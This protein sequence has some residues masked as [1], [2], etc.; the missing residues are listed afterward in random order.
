MQ[1][2]REKKEKTNEGE[3]RGE[4]HSIILSKRKEVRSTQHQ[5][6]HLS[7]IHYPTMVTTEYK[8]R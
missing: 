7:Y 8:I 1:E 5:G 6:L 4:T 2:A 3:G